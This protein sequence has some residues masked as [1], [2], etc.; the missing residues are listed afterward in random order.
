M[1]PNL[2][3]LHQL[4]DS[5]LSRQ[6]D[7]RNRV[8]NICSALGGFEAGV[9]VPGDE[10]TECLRDLK[11]I[12][13][14]DNETAER[15]V[16]GFFGEWNVLATDLLPL[17]CVTDVEE[18]Y[19]TAMLI[20][21][22]LV[23]LTWATSATLATHNSPNQIQTLLK[24]KESF[25]SE[26]VLEKIMHL[27]LKSLAIPWRDRSAKENAKI[28]LI[29]TLFRNLLAI[30]DPEVTGGASAEFQYRASLQEKLIIC[31]HNTNVLAIFLTFAASMDEKEFSDYNMLILEVVHLLFRDRTCYSILQDFQVAQSEALVKLVQADMKKTAG[32]PV[33]TR[34]SR[35]GGT[36]AMNLGVSFMFFVCVFFPPTRAHDSSY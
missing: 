21:E 35:F 18:T 7:D 3:Y 32:R 6:D 5:R 28:R 12:L 30:R 13:R 9:Y 19:K 31:F 26:P 2:A 1:D 15:K 29:I 20:V 14:A 24:Y 10:A 23:P 8:L 16:F 22:L 36:L 17:L 27:L 34:H 11:K 4:E 33:Q 25:L